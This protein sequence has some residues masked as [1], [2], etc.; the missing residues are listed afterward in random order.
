MLPPGQAIQAEFNLTTLQSPVRNA[1]ANTYYLHLVLAITM[2]KCLV[3]LAAFLL[4]D[5]VAAEK[6]IGERTHAHIAA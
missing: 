1:L 5:F 2:P 4:Q 3:L 6:T